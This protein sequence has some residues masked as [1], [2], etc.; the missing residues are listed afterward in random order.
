MGKVVIG[1]DIAYGALKVTA[2][3]HRGSRYRLAG[4]SYGVIP[5]NSWTADE[6]KN[7]DEISQTLKKCLEQAKPHSIKSNIAMI[8]LPEAAVFTT[9]FNVPELNHKELEMA[10]PFEIAD[11]LSVNLDDYIIDY[12]TSSSVCQPVVEAA[13]IKTAEEKS[14]KKT[15]EKAKDEPLQETEA[16][17]TDGAHYAVFAVAT[18]R[19]LVQSVEDFCKKCGLVLAGVDIKSDCIVRSLIH[20]DD[21]TMRLIVDLGAST[22]GLTVAEGMSTRLL[23]SIPLGTTLYDPKSSDALEK[24]KKESG[25]IFD[26][27][28]HVTKFYQN[29]VCPGQKISEIILSGGGSDI[30]GI[31]EVVAEKTALPTSVG[32]AFSKVDTHRFPVPREYGHKFADSVGLAMRKVDI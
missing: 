22:T 14:E 3:E 23:S 31:K 24:F 25:P 2:L 17:V 5:K 32:E 8:A 10:L 16:K 27:I 13:S 29:R 4:M 7:Q 9:V 18:K 12:E 19:T 28:M 11:K 15:K 1:I 21:R 20:N 26:E 30:D 6:L